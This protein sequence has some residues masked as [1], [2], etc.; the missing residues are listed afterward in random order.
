METRRPDYESAREADE[1]A[2]RSGDRNYRIGSDFQAKLE[3]FRAPGK[4]HLWI[5]PHGAHHF[6]P[7]HLLGGRR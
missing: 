2:L 3:A 5:S 4:D 6:H 1:A 7:F